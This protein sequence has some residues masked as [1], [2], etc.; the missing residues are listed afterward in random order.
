MDFAEFYKAYPRK[1]A[2]KDAE[3]AW[4]RLTPEEKGR[5]V[6]ALPK[7]IKYWDQ[8]GTAKEFIP[9]PATWLNGARYD[10]EIEAPSIPVK[11]V[12]WWASEDGVMAKGRELG[13]N[14]RGGESMQEYKAR[15]VEAARRAA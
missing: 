13:I 8:S 14:A 2:R 15:V 9:H 7:H 1:V 11:A 6:E 3:K 10:D 5:A 12:A 4:A